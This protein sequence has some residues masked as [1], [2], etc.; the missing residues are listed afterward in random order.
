MKLTVRLKVIGRHIAFVA[1]YFLY[2][3]GMLYAYTGEGIYFWDVFWH[4]LV[5]LCLFYFTAH[6]LLEY[7]SSFATAPQRLGLGI[8]LLALEF[9]A[10]LLLKYLLAQAYIY[11]EVRTTN[12]YVGFNNFL[13]DT[14]WRFITVNGLSFTY[15]FFMASSKKQRQV[16]L[17]EQARLKDLADQEIAKREFVTVENAFL[18]SQINSHFLFNTL[19]YLHSAVLHTNKDAGETILRLSD[20]MRYSLSTPSGGKVKLKEEIQH[21]S[22]I[23]EISTLKSAGR[24]HIDYRTTGAPGELEIIPLVLVTLAE[25]VLKYADLKVEA[26][27]AQFHC[28]IEQSLLTIKISNNK[29]KF[30]SPIGHGIGLKNTEKRLSRAYPNKYEL[31]ILNS[32]L[33]YQLT[34]TIQLS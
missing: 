12:P 11:F 9:S 30:V 2:E 21:I 5:N 16:A 1:A 17:L 4:L 6:Y 34:L 24:L 20:I 10:F 29:R 8:I 22:D 25:N 32:E 33:S 28:N 26:S 3:I 14:F 7:A 31:H 19:S 15:W 27:P 13:R 23:F 18:K